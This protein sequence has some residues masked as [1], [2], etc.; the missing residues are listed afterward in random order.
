MRKNVQHAGRGPS[1]SLNQTRP[2]TSIAV[3]RLRMFRCVLGASLL[4]SNTCRAEGFKAGDTLPDLSSSQLQG[5]LPDGLKGKVV[6]VDFW[7]SWCEPCKHSFPVMEE[8]H[9]KYGSQGLVVIAINVDEDAGDMDAFLKKN[10]ATFSVV[11]DARQKL[12][13]KAQIATMPS[14]FLVDRDGK[15]RHV[16]TGFRGEETAKKYREEI[17]ALLKK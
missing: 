6:L 1:G 2:S 10:Q 8:L 14:S 3:C 15:I 9:R 16:H 17:E 12:V 13:A 11:R 7:A 4:L 5:H